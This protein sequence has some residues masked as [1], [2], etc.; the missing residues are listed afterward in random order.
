[1]T[2][3]FFMSYMGNKRREINQILP[4][5]NI[6]DKDTICE[7]FCGSCA[8]SYNLWKQYPDKKYYMNDNC[9]LLIEL[10][11]KIKTTPLDEFIEEMNKRCDEFKL[12]SLEEMKNKI[13]EGATDIYEY[14]MFN[15]IAYINSSI[16]NGDRSIKFKIKEDF[17]NFICSPNVYFICNDWRYIFD[18]FNKNNTIILCDPPYLDTNNSKYTNYNKGNI[19]GLY[20]TMR[21]IDYMSDIYFIIPPTDFTDMCLEKYE[22]KNSYFITK[23]CNGFKK[24]DVVG[25]RPV[26]VYYR[27]GFETEH[28][29]EG[30]IRIGR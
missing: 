29:S 11:N 6:E 22:K 25:D 14:Y 13:K 23:T 28:T 16:I 2:S 20:M 7:P 8:M 15:K 30:V 24:W 12:L 18:T 17:Y 21:H 1:M 4:Y 27:K 19:L 5:I 26:C 9:Q 10:Y 3:H